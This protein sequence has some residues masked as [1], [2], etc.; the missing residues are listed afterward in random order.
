MEHYS[1]RMTR[2]IEDLLSLARIGL[3]ANTFPAGNADISAILTRVT[4]TCRPG[5]RSAKSI[6][7]LSRALSNTASPATIQKSNRCSRT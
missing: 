6:S 4:E 7:R 1:T 5:R 3:D 2:L